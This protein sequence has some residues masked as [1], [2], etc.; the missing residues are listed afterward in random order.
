MKTI[1]KILAILFVLISTSIYAQDSGVRDTKVNASLE[2]KIRS[3]KPLRIG[4]KAGVPSILTM[5][6][7]YVTP[8][9]N[10]RVALAV[11]YFKLGR[12]FDGTQI[13]YTNFEIGSNIYFNSKGKGLYGGISYTSFTSEGT[14]L[15]VD[16]ENGNVTGDGLADLDYNT[17]NLKLGTKMG[18]VFYMRIE[19]GYGFGSIP[20]EVLVRSIDNPSLTTLEEIPEIPGISDSGII[21]FNIG[22]GFGFL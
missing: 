7:E 15:D 2:E 8:L 12:E 4:I 19:A 18:R 5:N 20:T 11:D 16:F 1:S 14:F 13:D 21:Y 10:N 3:I 22:F 9:L 17:F 6:A